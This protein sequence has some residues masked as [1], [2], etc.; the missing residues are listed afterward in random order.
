MIPITNG[1]YTPG[2]AGRWSKCTKCKLHHTRTRVAT[3]RY[4]GSGHTKI[5]FIGEAPGQL[6]DVTGYPFVGVAGKILNH[7]IKHTRIQ[8]SYLITNVIG[9]RP[10]DVWFMDSSYDTKLEEDICD[11]D[12][13]TRNHTPTF[14]L[15]DYVLNEDYELHNWNRDPH[16]S[17]IEACKD[18]I[19]ELIEEY[20]PH[21]VI[22]LGK[23]AQSYK[24]K[25]PHISLFHPAYIARMEYKLLTVLQEARKIDQFLERLHK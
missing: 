9:C 18:H 15:N 23:I 5:L 14:N 11:D 3:K 24:T 22:H 20:K 13:L 25:L 8:F 4:G 10:V 21:G 1:K 6:E 12:G 19:T 17:E 7:T 16:P 2:D